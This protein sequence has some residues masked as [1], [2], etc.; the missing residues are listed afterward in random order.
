MRYRNVATIRVLVF[1][2]AAVAIATV[3]AAGQTAGSRPYTPAKTADLT[4][5]SR[6]VVNIGEGKEPLSAKEIHL[7][8][9]PTP[10]SNRIR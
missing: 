5:G 9:A 1:A 4:T 8:A 3:S 2:V 7:A 6:V 10:G